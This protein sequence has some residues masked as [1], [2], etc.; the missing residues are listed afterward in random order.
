MNSFMINQTF[1][2]RLKSMAKTL[3]VSQRQNLVE[4]GVNHPQFASLCESF[5]SLLVNGFLAIEEIAQFSKLCSVKEEMFLITY[6][7]AA[8]E[9]AKLFIRYLQH[10]VLPD[11]SKGLF[12]GSFYVA[13]T[14][15]ASD[16]TE[17]IADIEIG[18]SIQIEHE[19]SNPHDEKAIKILKADG[20]KLGYI[21]KS[22]NRFPHQMIENGTVLQGVIS[23][24]DWTTQG[25]TIKVMLYAKI[26]CNDT[27]E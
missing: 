10:S 14:A 25:I 1:K 3:N 9:A 13:G 16:I 21:P 27:I 11:S 18:T 2:E 5:E 7:S 26:D 24:R 15:Y 22:L 17:R 20:K 8:L 23:E 4:L 12:I 19:P 6:Q